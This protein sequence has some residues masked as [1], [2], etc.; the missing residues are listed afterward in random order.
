LYAREQNYMPGNKRENNRQNTFI[1]SSFLCSLFI[2]LHL[3]RKLDFL[4][5]HHFKK[6]LEEKLWVLFVSF[7]SFA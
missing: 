3:E 7:S 2:T 1:I 6:F 4:K 5:Y